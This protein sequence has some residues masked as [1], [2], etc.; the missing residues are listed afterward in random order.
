M[1]M[2]STPKEGLEEKP[3]IERI[4]DLRSLLE[5]K[6]HFLFGPRPPFVI[7]RHAVPK[8]SSAPWVDTFT[9]VYGEIRFV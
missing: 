7:A 3:Y 5:R 6:S 1:T 8:Q 2:A 4:L 9:D